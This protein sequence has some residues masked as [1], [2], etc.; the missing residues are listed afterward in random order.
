MRRR[1][2]LAVA[3]ILSAVAAGV[4]TAVLLR[5]TEREPRVERIVEVRDGRGPQL[6]GR[7]QS[8]EGRREASPSVEG[9]GAARGEAAP[10]PADSSPPVAGARR[11][12]EAR[13]VNADG[14]A[15]QGATAYAVPSGAPPDVADDPPGHVPKRPGATATGAMCAAP[16]EKPHGQT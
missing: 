3:W 7:S 12:I 9:S 6:R 5:G 11:W 10:S 8:D 15:A 4:V 14:S 1:A 16:T 13:V 2:V